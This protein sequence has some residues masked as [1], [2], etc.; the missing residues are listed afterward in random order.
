MLKKALLL[1][2]VIVFIIACSTSDDSNPNPDSTNP[3][4]FDRGAVLTN[5]ADNIIIP[6]YTDLNLKLADLVAKKD[7]F[8]ASPNA[9]NLAALRNSWLRAYKVWQS[10]EMFNIGPAEQISLTFQ[11]NVYPT[12]VSDI[13]SNIQSGNY[14]LAQV[15][16]NDAVGFPAL[17]YLL[18]GL[19]N[20]DTDILSFYTTNSN[21]TKYLNYLSDVTNQMK[22]LAQDVLDGWSNYR[23][24]FI[25]S[26]DNTVSSALNKLVNDFVFYYEKGLRAN[27]IGIPAGNFSSNTLPEKVEAYYK[28]DISKEL[29]T[30]ALNAVKA[31]F[32][33]SAYNGTGE[34]LKSYLDFLNTIK[35]G[36][37]LSTIINN[38]FNEAQSKINLLDNNFANQINTD[39]TKMTQAYDALQMAVV[40][41]KVDMLQAMDVNVDYV[42]ADGD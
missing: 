7:D 13:E 26:T 14:D 5:W 27:K 40:L 15:N 18:Y 16:N 24:E 36:E 6:T 9:T 28:S 3:G 2:T 38:Q 31:F 22:L 12:N 11:M 4:N 35:D 10:A 42:D 21:A 20:T 33:G 19:A 41:L 30:D 39:N 17:D 29:A 8:L 1:V 23:T 25:S 37:D 32:N 34:S